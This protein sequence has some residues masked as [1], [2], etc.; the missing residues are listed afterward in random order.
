MSLKEQ[1]FWDRV[2]PEPNSGCFL[3]TAGCDEKGY[4]LFRFKGVTYRAHRFSYE[5]HKGKIP[6]A[7]MIDHLCSVRCCVNPAHLEAVSAQENALRTVHRG[8]HQHAKKTHC[9]NGHPYA[10]ENL[11]RINGERRCRACLKA[12]SRRHQARRKAAS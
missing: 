4:A 6:K 7:L 9:I 2:T 5:L 12:N 8:R 11:I 1:K 3:W 10:G